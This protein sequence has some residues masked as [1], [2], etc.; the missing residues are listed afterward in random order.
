MGLPAT[1]KPIKFEDAD[2][3]ELNADGKCISHQI[4]NVGEPL[5]QIGYGSLNNPNTNGV[6]NDGYGNFAKKDM[7]AFLAS[8]SDDVVFEIQDRK[9]DSKPRFF[10]G[11][12]EVGKFFEELDTKFQY[13]KFQPVRFVADGDDVFVLID[14]E[15][16]LLSTGQTFAS[17]Y[18]H[19]F[20]VKN[21]K[22]AYFRGVDDFQL[23]K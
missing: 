22:I 5:R 23:M 6:L 14:A 17:T 7:K 2:V 1:G 15:Y 16:K 11:K 13:T 9:F 4:T 21:G 19:H 12:T 10:R 20:V 3:V 8:C 18:T